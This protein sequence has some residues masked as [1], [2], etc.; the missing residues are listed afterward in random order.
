MK[1]LLDTHILLWAI[2]KTGALSETVKREIKKP[3]NQILVSAVS[4]WEIALKHSLGKLTIDFEIQKIPEY[5]EKMEFDLIPLNPAEA[6]Q[7]F[8]L[9]QKANHRDPFDRLLIYQCIFS[10]YTLAS[11]DNRIE[12]YKKDGLNFIR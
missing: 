10:G 6:L 2:G 4:L 3:D 11:I 8:R 12:Q 5:C 7:S 9:P 1:L